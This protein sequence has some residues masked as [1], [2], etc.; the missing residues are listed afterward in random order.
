MLF[1][2]YF[3]FKKENK[4][5][6]FLQKIEIIEKNS[7]KALSRDGILLPYPIL[8]FESPIQSEYAGKFSDQS[9]YWS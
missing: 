5:A 2:S 8:N 7:Y 9:D 6:N 1:R 4:I 3:T